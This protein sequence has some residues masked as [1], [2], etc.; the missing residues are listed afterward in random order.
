MKIGILSDTHG[1]LSA[2]ELLRKGVFEEVDLLIHAG[3]VLYHGPRNPLPEGYDPNKLAQALNEEKVPLFFAKGNCDA[4][5][6]QLL[7]RFPLMNPF[8]VLFVEGLTI[9]VVHELKENLFNL[10]K[11][12]NPSCVI[13]GHT[14]KPDLRKE[15]PIL[16]NPGSPSLPKEGPPTVGLLD[17]S[18][19]SV[20][21]LNLKGD[22]LKEIK[23]R[24]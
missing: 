18:L 4:E 19:A 14:H 17:T 23:I 10:L 16:F 7:I 12:Y 9:L 22:I 2:W 11:A 24:R 3:D 6:D 20:K 15:G 13:Y 5:V 21:L 8:L 1:S